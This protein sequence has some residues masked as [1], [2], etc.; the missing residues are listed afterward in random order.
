MTCCTGQSLEALAASARLIS[1]PTSHAA[2][3]SIPHCGCIP[4]IVASAFRIVAAYC[5][6]EV[7]VKTAHL[8][9]MYITG[10][11]RCDMPSAVC[12][13]PLTGH[14]RVLAVCSFGQTALLCVQGLE[15]VAAVPALGQF[16]KIQKPTEMYRIPSGIEMYKGM[17]EQPS[18]PELPAVIAAEVKL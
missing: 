3:L 17:Q 16:K 2:G 11:R 12:R 10:Q 13:L 6:V 1:R 18:A 7:D 4:H 5:S 8:D 15:K 9:R 14:V